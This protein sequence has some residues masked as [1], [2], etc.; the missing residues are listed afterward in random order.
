MFRGRRLPMFA[1]AAG[2]L[3]L[4]VLLATLQ[5]RWLGQI[6]A[7]ER[8]RMGALLRDNASGFAEDF[9]R[10]L[11]R[12]YLMFQVVPVPVGDNAAAQIASR[13]DRWMA[14]SQYPRLV[15]D[16]YL[17]SA[18]ASGIALQR[19][20]LSTRVLEP[21]AWPA[22]L[23]PVRQRIG[24]LGARTLARGEPAL[25]HGPVQAIWSD[26]PA[27][28]VSAPLVLVDRPGTVARDVVPA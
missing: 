6:S 14:T 23:A 13:Y 18:G 7:A 22:A 11:N 16:V 4:I 5:Y 27:L 8:A 26:V 9:D 28:V 12:A 10:E 1:L 25:L 19:F 17:A 2:L 3:G 21:A 20:N 24:S 15:Q